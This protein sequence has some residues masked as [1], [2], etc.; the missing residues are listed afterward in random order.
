M[1]IVEVVGDMINQIVHLTNV[2][3]V[4]TVCGVTIGTTWGLRK[5]YH[6]AGQI[7]CKECRDK[8]ASKGENK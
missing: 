5:V 8:L 6:W 7:G 4:V 1:Y 2:S 3:A